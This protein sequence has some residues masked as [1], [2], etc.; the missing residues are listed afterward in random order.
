MPAR[1]DCTEPIA[2]KGGTNDGHEVRGDDV[3][4]K[5]HEGTAKSGEPPLRLASRF[6]TAIHRERLRDEIVAYSQPS[7]PG[8]ITFSV[9]VG[10]GYS[11]R[12]QPSIR[13]MDETACVPRADPCA[14]RFR[15]KPR[16]IAAKA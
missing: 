11:D 6:A 15:L 4:S 1:A 12:R 8:R 13:Q 2:P 10:T 9:R 5:I 14:S 16:E 7:G 3:A